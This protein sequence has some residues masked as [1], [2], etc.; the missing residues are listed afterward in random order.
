[1]LI[2][3]AIIGEAQSGKS[4][5]F[6]I[7][8]GKEI[9]FAEFRKH[10]IEIKDE[11]LNEIA[12]FYGKEKFSYE[13]IE[14][15]DTPPLDEKVLAKC[16][17]ATALI[18]LVPFFKQKPNLDSVI[19]PLTELI[20]SDLKICENRLSKLRFEDTLEKK[21]LSKCKQY[22]EEQKPLKLLELSEAEEKMLRGFAFLTQ[23]PN[24]FLINTGE[25][26]KL[27]KEEIERMEK[28]VFSKVKVTNLKIEEELLELSEEDR[29]IFMKEYGIK[30]FIAQDILKELLSEMKVVT[31]FTKAGKEARAWFVRDGATV[32]ECAG[33]IHSDMQKGF[34]KAEVI[35]FKEIGGKPQLVGKDYKVRDG[36]IIEIKFTK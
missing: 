30:E 34:V 2:T 15:I 21:L 28:K 26:Q 20:L 19:K 5:L 7:L 22:L 8:T 36:D 3:I 1:M 11:R 29:K 16:K 6:K 14:L 4:T 12:K 32:Y 25:E 9:E 35:N 23:K 13:K 24:I 27:D 10:I 33:L 17:E 31:F 18:I